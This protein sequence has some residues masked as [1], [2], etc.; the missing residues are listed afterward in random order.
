MAKTDEDY[1]DCDHPSPVSVLLRRLTES[2]DDLVFATQDLFTAIGSVLAPHCPQ[3]CQAGLDD[4][5]KDTELVQ[6]LRHL[7]RRF[8]EIAEGIRIVTDR[9]EL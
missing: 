9:V 1:P 2:A 4:V 8:E 6:T 5:G 3:E 7:R